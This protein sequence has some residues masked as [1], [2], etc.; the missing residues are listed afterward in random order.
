MTVRSLL[1]NSTS[2]F[3]DSQQHI[4]ITLDVFQQ[5]LLQTFESRNIPGQAPISELFDDVN[6]RWFNDQTI[7]FEPNNVDVLVDGRSQTKSIEQFCTRLELGQRTTFELNIDI[8]S[9]YRVIDEVNDYL[10]L[11]Q[12]NQKFLGQ[13]LVSRTIRNV[14]DLDCGG[15]HDFELTFEEVLIL[16]VLSDRNRSRD[17]LVRSERDWRFSDLLV[18]HV[19]DLIRYNVFQRTRKDRRCETNTNA[20]AWVHQH[21]WHQWQEMRRFHHGGVV[22]VDHRN[23]LDVAIHN[24]FGECACLYGSVTSSTTSICFQ[25]STK[26]TETFQEWNVVG[27]DLS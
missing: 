13:R 10:L 12:I 9:V 14:G 2:I 3:L 19:L 6:I 26:R 4:E 16:S 7:T 23:N 27:I 8:N 5:K 17:S 21:N 22:V 24:V 20:V 11:N 25:A 18:L 1:R 15:I